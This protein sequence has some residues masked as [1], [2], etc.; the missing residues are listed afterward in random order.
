MKVLFPQFSAIDDADITAWLVQASLRWTVARLGQQWEM[1][2]YLYAAHQL[3]LNP[4]DGSG[5]G[6]GAVGAVTSESVGDV[7]RS[8]GDGGLSVANVPSSL[9]GFLST[10]Y[11]VELIGLLLSRSRYRPRVIRTG[12]SATTSS[13]STE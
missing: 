2:A 7:S 13:G 3:T 12:A 4:P 10:R 1:I 8:W 6:G 11:G 5:S 9:V